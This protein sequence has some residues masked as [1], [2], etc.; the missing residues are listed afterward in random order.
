MGRLFVFGM[1]LGQIR[2]VA[3]A[4]SYRLVYLE[5]RHRI[6]QLLRQ[7]V[8]KNAP[9]AEELPGTGPLSVELNELT[10]EG[11]FEG[12]RARVPAGEVVLVTGNTGAGK[13][14]LLEAIARTFDATAGSI[15]LDGF[16]LQEIR[17]SSLHQAVKL[18]SPSLPLVRGSVR[19]N[20]TYGLK[21]L[22]DSDL[23]S[24]AALCGLDTQQEVLPDGLDTSISEGAENL[25]EGVT[26]RINLARA[27]ARQPRL[28][29]VDHPVFNSDPEAIAALNRTLAGNRLTALVTGPE[30]FDFPRAN[31]VWD[32]K[33]GRV[34]VKQLQR[35]SQG[36]V[37]S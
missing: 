33:E 23:T 37:A 28:L 36:S 6:E 34:V 15:L 13:T 3:R 10:V 12:L 5:G 18:V 4:W 22:S 26:A 9:N 19:S 21:D 14:S 7:P 8:I 2:D 16:K 35:P 29:L 1:I 27:L 31:R 25:P 11:A 30:N 20:I 24:I 17:L 32:L